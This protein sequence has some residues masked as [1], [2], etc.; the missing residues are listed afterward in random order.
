MRRLIWPVLFLFL[1]LFQG[2]ISVFYTGWLSCDLLLLALYSYAGLRG[3]KLGA[4]AGAGVGLLQDALTV[5]VFGYH[6]LSRA[7]LGY[8]IGLT[9][10]KVVKENPAYHITAIAICSL[11]LRFVFFWLELLANGG[12]WAIFFDYVWAAIGFCIGNMLLVVP[13][14]KLIKFVYDWIREEDISY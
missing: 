9:K 11:G 10:E 6:I 7:A 12:Q 1:L 2:A 8:L 5:G 13:M 4:V 3:E 14:V